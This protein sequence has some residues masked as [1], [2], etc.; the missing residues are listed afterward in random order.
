[1]RSSPIWLL[2]LVGMAFGQTVVVGCNQDADIVNIVAESLDASVHI[3]QWS[4]VSKEDVAALASLQPERLI[5]IG[6]PIAVPTKVEA[7]GVPSER[8]GGKNRIETAELSMKKYLG[9]EIKRAFLLPSKEAIGDALDRK[10]A[11]IIPGNSPVS[12][13]WG[14]YVAYKL[15]AHFVRAEGEAPIGDFTIFVGNTKN[16]PS[17]A[18]AWQATGLPSQLTFYPTIY[19]HEDSLFLTGSDQNLPYIQRGFEQ[20][21][22]ADYTIR[23]IAVF[24]LFLLLTLYLL[25][26]LEPD[27]RY[28][29]AVTAILL[30]FVIVQLNSLGKMQ[31]AYDGLFGYFD[32]ALS[33][34]FT[35]TYRPILV[36]KALPGLSIFTY[37][38]LLLTGPT[39]ANAH[40]MLSLLRFWVLLL[41]YLLISKKSKA[42]G[43]SAILVLMTNPFFQKSASVYSS[44]VLFISLTLLAVYTCLKGKNLQ[45]LMALALAFVTRLSAVLLVFAIALNIRRARYWSLLSLPLGL[46]IIYS[47]GAGFSGYA[48]EQL[49]AFSFT[50]VLYYLVEYLVEFLVLV[51]IPLV[52]PLAVVVR[53]PSDPY[54]KILSVYL[55]LYII[56]LSF[57][58]VQD[59]RYLYV[60]VPF[61]ISLALTYK[62]KWHYFILL[63]TL[64]ANLWFYLNWPSF[65]ILL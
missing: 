2:I 8:T 63:F 64:L 20:L 54:Q 16:N 12:D 38:Y 58:F 10:A 62:T 40:L 32:G 46:L 22:F 48:A 33:L 21:G 15:N 4:K 59:W 52:I 56:S 42:A 51:G 26:R 53:R 11:T 19:L 37:A 18:E 6:G 24:S 39:D 43:I 25:Y 47:F 41:S 44:E 17:L 7:I 57:W 13:R 30:L 31:I 61:S 49:T 14:K 35:G 65:P 5:I 28:S 36:G 9:L 3:T 50:N 45:M 29:G 1:M 60:L 27:P 55:P 23:D 34:F